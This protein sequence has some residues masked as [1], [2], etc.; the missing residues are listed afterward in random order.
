MI[1][2]LGVFF[3][4]TPF[5]PA[6]NREWRPDALISRAGS[7]GPL[8][9]GA[10]FAFA[11]TPCVGPDARLDPHRRLG[12]GHRRQGR[13]SC[14]SFYSLGL[15]V[16]FLLT[17]VAFTRAT[18]A[19]RWLRDRYLI[20]TAV[21]G[22]RAD[23]DGRAAV[24]RRADAA[25]HRG[26]AG[27]GLGRPELLRRARPLARCRLP[28]QPPR[29]HDQADG[30]PHAAIDRRGRP[31]TSPRPA[32]RRRSSRSNALT[33]CV[34]R[35]EV[36]DR[37]CSQSGASVEREPDAR[38]ERDRQERQLRERHRLVGGLHERRRRA[39]PSDARQAAPS[40]S[41]TIAAGSVREVD[42]RRRT[43]ARRRRTAASTAAMPVSIGAG[44]A[45]TPR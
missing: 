23:R 6:L 25:Q 21:S 36:G 14:C 16:P 44:A 33:M 38:D 42:R 4:L 39:R 41:V 13:R 1:I 5:V 35:E 20:I 29:R 27:A 2:A 8:I 22:R 24:H 30:D 31:A 43:P 3:L 26:P 12:P 34:E 45:T 40:A 19:F 11:W 17:A 7:G 10:A 28:P 18:T 9:A 15:A 32:R 37:R